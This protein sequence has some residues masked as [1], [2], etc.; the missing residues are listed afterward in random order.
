MLGPAP[1]S[2][3]GDLGVPRF[4]CLTARV[5]RRPYAVPCE[6]IAS[7]SQS[8]LTGTAVRPGASWPGGVVA[9]LAA[10]DHRGDHLD[11][12]AGCKHRC[13]VEERSG[14]EA[15]NAAPCPRTRRGPP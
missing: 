7:M 9:R 8:E 13:N 12:P 4:P 1:A 14:G 2:L 6:L 10:T 3:G 5:K 11:R 15:P